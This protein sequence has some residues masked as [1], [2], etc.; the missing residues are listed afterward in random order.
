MSRAKKKNMEKTCFKCGCKKDIDSFYAHSEMKDGHLGKC[1]ECTKSDVKKHYRMTFIE[2]QEY[3]RSRQK[4]PERRAKKLEY[5]KK[6]RRNNPDKAKARGLIKY[7]VR[8]GKIKRKPC[9]VCGR[10]KSHAHHTDYSRPL[11]VRWLCATHHAMAHGRLEHT[12]VIE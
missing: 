8:T 6:H 9:E 3:E 5:S 2:R 11:D 12:K 7:A 10:E 1:K 4:D